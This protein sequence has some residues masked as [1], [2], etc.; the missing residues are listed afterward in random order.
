MLSE[1]FKEKVKL[2]TDAASFSNKKRVPLLSNDY[3]WKVYD[4]GIGFRDAY[5]KTKKMEKIVCGFHERYNFDAYI[6]LGTRNHFP[7]MQALGG[8]SY[9]LDEKTGGINVTD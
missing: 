7:Q 5:F 1:K 6:D 2:F 8:G 3:T 9:V 4:S